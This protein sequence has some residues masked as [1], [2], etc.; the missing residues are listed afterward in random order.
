MNMIENVI[1]N[2]EIGKLK[3]APYNPRVKLEEGMP[4]YERLKRASAHS[5]ILSLSCGISGPGTL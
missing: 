4:E 3:E 2:V 5:G 1:E